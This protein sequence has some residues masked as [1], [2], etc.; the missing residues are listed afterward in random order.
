MQLESALSQHGTP[1]E[2][3]GIAERFHLS[4]QRLVQ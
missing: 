4:G 1:V 3:G 2:G